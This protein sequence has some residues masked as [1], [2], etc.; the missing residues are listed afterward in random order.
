[1]HTLIWK[2]SGNQEIVSILTG[3][4]DEMKRMQITTAKYAARIPASLKEMIEV[5]DALLANDSERCKEKMHVHIANLLKALE[6][7]MEK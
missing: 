6:T 7:I 1:M 5:N 2:L 3:Y 4:H